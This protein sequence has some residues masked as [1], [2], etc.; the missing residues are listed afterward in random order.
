MSRNPIHT[1]IFK[2]ARYGFRASAF[3]L[4]AA[5]FLLITFLSI[6]AAFRVYRQAA[7]ERAAAVNG[8]RERWLNQDPKHPHI[9]AHFGNFAFMPVTP[10]SFFD[11]GLNNFTGT[12]AYLEPHK[13]NDFAF[14]PAVPLKNCSQTSNFT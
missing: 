1:I 4:T 11:Q 8:Q 2:E 13:Q 9:A 12:A 7:E 14:K 5:L 6:L 3:R 10:L